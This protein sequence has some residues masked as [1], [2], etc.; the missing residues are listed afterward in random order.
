MDDPIDPIPLDFTVTRKQRATVHAFR[1]IVILWLIL[2]TL[3]AI[4]R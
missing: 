1:V 4:W 2:L 3:L